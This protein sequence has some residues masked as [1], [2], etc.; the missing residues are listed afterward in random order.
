MNKKRNS[1]QAIPFLILII[2]FVTIISNTIK[3]GKLE[4]ERMVQAYNKQFNEHKQQV[5][6]LISEVEYY[7]QIGS[8]AVTQEVI[9]TNYGT[10]DGT[11][12]N[13]TASGL[14]IKDFEINKEGM[15]TYK[16]NVVLA[17]ANETRWERKLKNGFSSHDLYEKIAFELEGKSYTG[18]VLDV[19]GACMGNRSETLQRYDIF[20][21][22]DVV[23]KKKGV[24]LE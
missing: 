13:T 9:F 22:K 10:W 6:A 24:V 14:K 1:L 2:A 19:C 8:N 20:T 17:T 7:A 15:Y 12:G 4:Q 18:V 5:Q 11:S 23:G 21:T 3:Q 16:G